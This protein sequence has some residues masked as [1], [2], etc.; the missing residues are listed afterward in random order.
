MK[1]C[2]LTVTFVYF[3]A[4]QGVLQPLQ[5]PQNKGR[6]LVTRVLTEIEGAV[7]IIIFALTFAILALLTLTLAGSVASGT[8]RRR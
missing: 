1:N 8:H 5:S 4:H 3:C 6:P 2:R 7:M